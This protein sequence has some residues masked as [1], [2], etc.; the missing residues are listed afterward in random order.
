MGIRAAGVT[1][2]QRPERGTQ[3]SR[4]VSSPLGGQEGGAL[5]QIPSGAE[6]QREVGRTSKSLNSSLSKGESEK[7]SISKNS[8][9]Q[10]LSKT[11]SRE[12]GPTC[13]AEQNPD[14]ILSL[15]LENVPVPAG[16]LTTARE[17]FQ[18][19]MT[20]LLPRATSTLLCTWEQVEWKQSHKFGGKKNLG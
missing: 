18:T 2:K 10:R 16:S 9:F 3:C 8:P 14:S 11:C 1:A 5:C 12:T 20:H 17:P 7:P 13:Q 4:I 19:H 15:V 6:P